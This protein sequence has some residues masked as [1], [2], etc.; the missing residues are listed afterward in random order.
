M[1]EEDPYELMEMA[2]S[3]SPSM[4]AKFLLRGAQIESPGLEMMFNEFL[5]SETYRKCAL[6]QTAEYGL[7]TTPV[8][9]FLQTQNWRVWDLNRGKLYIGYDPA[10]KK[11]NRWWHNLRKAEVDKTKRALPR[12]YGDIVVFRPY[13]NL[14]CEEHELREE[15]INFAIARFCAGTRYNF[16]WD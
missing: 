15:L 7:I 3:H 13:D 2:L 5:G 10:A 16:S 12:M 4:Q 14:S 1:E 8:S 6:C 11:V 9:I